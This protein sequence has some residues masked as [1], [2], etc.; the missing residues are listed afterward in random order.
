VLFSSA[1]LARFIN[2]HFEPVWESV[3]PVPMLTID[4]GNGKTVTRTLHGNIAT[5]LCGHE[6]QVLDIVPGIYTPEVYRGRLHQFLL[7]HQ[8]VNGRSPNEVLRDYHQKQAEL[9]KANQQ[10]QIL[11]RLDREKDSIEKPIKLIAAADAARN[12]KPAINPQPPKATSKADEIAR[13]EVLAEDT[14][15]NESIR[16]EQIHRKLAQTGMVKP[17]QIVKWLYKDVLHA[18]LD[19]PYLGLGEALFKNYPF[20]E[21]EA[22]TAR[23]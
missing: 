17:D 5:Y 8:Y 14:K 15:L 18:D 23:P 4:F 1:D 20:A 12:A 19:D 7:L 22:R 21:E 9:L 11:V 3:R 13:W 2:D 6:G 16:R 10:P